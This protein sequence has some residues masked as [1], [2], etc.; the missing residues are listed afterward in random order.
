MS[1]SKEKSMLLSQLIDGEL[2]VEQA[3]E[4]LAE[5]L[6]ELSHVLGSFE[7][8]RQLYAMLQLRRTLSPWRQQEPSK[9]VVAPPMHFVGRTSP[10]RRQVMSLASAA[11]LGGILV[12]G[13]FFLSSLLTGP[14]HGGP[15]ASQTKNSAAVCEKATG[16]D[17]QPVIVVTP[18]QRREIANAFA[19]HESV[20]GPLSWYA[21]DDSTIQVAPAEKGEPM[22]E[23]IAVVLRLTQDCPGQGRVSIQPKTYVIVCR[24]NDTATIKL[25]PSAMAANLRLRLLS[26]ASNAHVKLQYVLA[27]DSP[28]QDMEDAVLAGGRHVGLDQTS[29]G[30]LAMNDCL[31]NIDASAWVIQNEPKIP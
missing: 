23:P 16:R 10:L 15:I 12:A 26:T 17:R 9:V 6:G 13:G 8:A 22:R 19:L 29:L 3:N 7:E 20:A 14:Q 1:L 25:P 27:A 31:V 18:E 28:K 4:V 2:P 5:V 11:V 21:A 30:Q 24:N